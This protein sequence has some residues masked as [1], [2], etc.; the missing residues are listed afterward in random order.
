MTQTMNQTLCKKMIY[1][2]RSKS[3]QKVELTT[4]HS[5][6]QQKS[7]RSSLTRIKTE[8]NAKSTI[9]NRSRAIHPKFIFLLLYQA[10]HLETT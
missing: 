10:C 9:T 2:P 7:N 4:I 8:S 3:N 1:S 6:Q 5:L